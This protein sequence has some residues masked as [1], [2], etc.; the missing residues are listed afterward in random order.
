MMGEAAAE[1]CCGSGTYAR[2]SASTAPAH[3]SESSAYRHTQAARRA[4]MPTNSGTDAG[5]DSSVGLGRRL[6]NTLP[7]DVGMGLGAHMR[8]AMHE[9]WALW[10]PAST[11]AGRYRWPRAGARTVLY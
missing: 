5:A 3:M 4:G 10:L 2:S 8:A 1:A 11:G 6:P 7:G 9:G